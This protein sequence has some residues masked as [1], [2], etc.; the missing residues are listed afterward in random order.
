MP[1]K[2]HRGWQAFDSSELPLQ[3]VGRDCQWIADANLSGE[4]ERV[5]LA[6]EFAADPLP[7]PAEVVIA[8]SA[9]D[10]QNNASET[11]FSEQCL[12]RPE[13]F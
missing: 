11:G 10:M 2:E 5:D 1:V 3:I 9:N 13:V 7:M 12:H 4:G 8:E 6:G